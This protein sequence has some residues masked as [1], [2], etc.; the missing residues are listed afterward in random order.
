[1]GYR[2]KQKI[3]NWIL[4]GWEAPKKCTTFWV[5]REMQIKTILR[6]HLKEVRMAK[7]KKFMW[8]Q[9][10]ARMWRKR[11]TPLLMVG[12]QAGT[13]T[14]DIS[15][16]VSWEIGHSITRGSSNTTP[17]NIPEDVSLWNMDT[18]F[19]MFIAAFFIISRSWKE[20]RYLSTVKW[21]QKMLYIYTMEYYAV[22][23]INKF[24]K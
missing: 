2:A 4:N 3:L 16:A 8:Q 12:L 21:V 5:I 19:I 11:T 18:C 23:K 10:L 13:I 15:L 24:V 1:M 17:G 6:F 7:I 14:L 22:I 9:M 20:P